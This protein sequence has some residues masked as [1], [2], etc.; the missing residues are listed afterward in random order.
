MEKLAIALV[1]IALVLVAATCSSNKN[2]DTGKVIKSA[3]VGNNLIA[4]L[5]NGDAV[6]KNGENEFLISFRDDAGKTV[7][8]G[9]VGLTLHMP[10]MGT[11][12]AMN[13]AASFT[14]T[15]TPGIYQG[16]VKLESTGDWQAQV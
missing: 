2:I 13:A 6:I 15:D 4:T 11:M 8:V 3:P 10:A 14:A 1:L 7:E 12:P 5:S 16:K 9:A